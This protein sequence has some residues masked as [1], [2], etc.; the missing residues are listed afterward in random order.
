V[1]FAKPL[2]EMQTDNRKDDGIMTPKKNK[3]HNPRK[4]TEVKP[5]IA[6]VD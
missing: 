1:Q 3:E 4:V 2:G 6:K 5:V